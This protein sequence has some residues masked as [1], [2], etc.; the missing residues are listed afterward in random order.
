MKS[1]TGSYRSSREDENAIRVDTIPRTGGWVTH[2]VLPKN[3]SPD[4]RMKMLDWVGLYR[5]KIRS[6]HPDWWVS[7]RTCTHGYRL[8]VH[9]LSDIEGLR[10]LA[11]NETDKAFKDCLPSYANDD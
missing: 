9:A 11:E 6:E 1:S 3:V 5:S 2:V 7:F 8:V 4:D 10:H